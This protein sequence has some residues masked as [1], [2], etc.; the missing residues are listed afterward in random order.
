MM[1]MSDFLFE[2]SI[3]SKKKVDFPRLLS[4]MADACVQEDME[5]AENPA[6]SPK[7]NDLNIIIN[8]KNNKYMIII[9]FTVIFHKRTMKFRFFSLSKR[10]NLKSDLKSNILA[11]VIIVVMVVAI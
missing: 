8:G 6:E 4:K 9:I 1:V 5:V 7:I 11:I 3:T 10:V 2:A